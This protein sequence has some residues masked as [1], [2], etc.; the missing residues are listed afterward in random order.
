MN[1]KSFISAVLASL[2]FTGCTD[3]PGASHH[4][5][6]PIDKWPEGAVLLLGDHQ[7]SAV[8]EVDANGH[9]ISQTAY[10]PYGAPRGGELTDPHR[11]VGNEADSGSGLADFH[12]RPYRAD[13]GL[14]LSVDPNL[15]FPTSI[16]DAQLYPYAYAQG[17]PIV[18]SDPDGRCP[19]CV[20]ILI[21]LGAGMATA[22]D[23]TPRTRTD[24]ELGRPMRSPSPLWKTGAYAGVFAAGGKLDA[25]VGPFWSGAAM[26]VGSRGIE[27]IDQGHVSSIGSYVESALFGGL[28]G[29][30]TADIGAL[31]GKAKQ[32]LS[33]SREFELAEPTLGVVSKR[34]PPQITV[35]GNRDDTTV[36]LGWPGHNVLRIPNEEWSLQLNIRWLSSAIRRGDQIY[37]ATDPKPWIAAHPDTVL[38]HEMNF[39][40]SQGFRQEGV[41]MVRKP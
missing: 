28:F 37:L 24:E 1:R 13:A 26:G 36:A 18:Y 21:G 9:P 17:N 27:D 25:S 16:T 32:L 30:A 14:F 39:L 35:I 2:I 6:K 31:F 22:S 19:I 7:G 41:Y 15:L 11:F 8:T 34:K 33:P 5:G 20:V 3:D 29:K 23:A 40:E 4:G 10:H 12:A 38:R